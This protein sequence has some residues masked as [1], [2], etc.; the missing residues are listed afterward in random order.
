[1]NADRCALF[2]VDSKSNELYAN[3][4]DDGDE[5]GSGYKF[6]NGVEIRCV[7][8]QKTNKQTDRQTDKHANCNFNLS[9]IRRV[10]CNNK[11][12]KISHVQLA[13]V[14]YRSYVTVCA[15]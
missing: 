7:N 8:K 3:L 1:M 12:D 5:D 15:S 2:M 14:A 6:R 4:F 13:K 10:K 9:D 11:K